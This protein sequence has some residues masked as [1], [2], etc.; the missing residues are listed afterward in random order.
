M[1][2]KYTND[3][4]FQCYKDQDEDLAWLTQKTEESKYNKGNF[5]PLLGM[6]FAVHFLCY[7]QKLQLVV[8]LEL[9]FVALYFYIYELK[10][11]V[12]DF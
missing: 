7:F 10:K 6:V 1:N 2:Q 12:S 3:T 5:T 4:M 11:C 9:I 8:K